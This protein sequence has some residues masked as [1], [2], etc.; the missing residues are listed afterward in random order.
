M[1]HNMTEEDQDCHVVF[2]G[3]VRDGK[4]EIGLEFSTRARLSGASLSPRRL[5]PQAS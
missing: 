2:L 1:K 4:A 5:D 3:P